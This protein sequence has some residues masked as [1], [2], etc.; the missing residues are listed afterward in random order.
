[1]FDWTYEIVY[2]HD[3]AQFPKN[4]N[5]S[6]NTHHEFTNWASDLCKNHQYR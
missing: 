2:K 3:E 4:L 6:K 5:I 1:M